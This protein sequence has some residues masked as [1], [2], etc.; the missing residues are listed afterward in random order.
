MLFFPRFGLA[1][2]AAVDS[3]GLLARFADEPLNRYGVHTRNPFVAQ[4]VVVDGRVL[5]KVIVPGR[6]YPPQGAV[7]PLYLSGRRSF[8]ST[9]ILNEVPALDW[10][11]GC[12]ATSAAMLFGYYDRSGWPDI[13]TGPTD[14]GL[15]PLTNTVWGKA[16]INGELRS[17]CPLSAT[18]KGL[19]G[20][21]SR[22]HVDDY[23]ICLND[24]GPDPY[25]VGGWSEHVQGDCVA[26]FMGTSQ[27]KFGIPDGATAFWFDDE[28]YP[29]VNYTGEE[30]DSRDGSYGM[31][32]FALSRGYDVVIVYNQY[33][34]GW[35]GGAVHGFTYEQYR[36]E[37]DCGRPVVIQLEGHTILGYGYEY[38]PAAS[39][40]VRE[41]IIN[42]TWDHDSHRMTW[43]GSYA[44]MPQ[45][46]VTVIRLGTAPLL[47]VL[48][49]A[50]DFGTVAVASSS[51]QQ[52]VMV[53]NAGN[54]ELAIADLRLAGAGAA[55]FA[56]VQDGCSGTTLA[57]GESKI[58]VLGFATADA[59]EF[60]ARLEI[61]SY[62]PEQ[63]LLS[64]PLTGRAL[65]TLY[66]DSTGQC[67]GK[68]PCY[69]DP[70]AALA[71]VEG[72]MADALLLRAGEYG[73]E[74]SYAGS[75]WLRVS[76][77]W[78]GDYSD[79]RSGDTSSVSRLLLAGGGVEVENLTLAPQSTTAAFLAGDLF[80]AAGYPAARKWAEH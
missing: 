58:V 34:R 46:G 31:R 48:P 76:G 23:W 16:E 17:L 22:G 39:P 11:F 13:Y 62:D 67:D 29:L 54:A 8:G 4:R 6:P 51:A 3:A 79:N 80:A 45:M 64:L 47:Y 55:S 25:I 20:R 14:N 18:R 72:Q 56:I 52:A 50:L 33:I 74:M 75:R 40:P 44:E 49:T 5:E 24:M 66:V 61:V 78:N 63:P 2:D 32:L 68:S 10:C 59:G 69:A 41:V 21:I 38:D 37:I 27:S 73:V 60:S 19:D 65:K 28:G 12:S 15:F 9:R 36:H 70:A 7:R 1:A 35:D 53:G 71:V 43:G 42:D 26:D 57:P 30:F 77:G